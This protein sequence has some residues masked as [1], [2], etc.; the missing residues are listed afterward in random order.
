MSDRLNEK[1]T[2]EFSI[3]P[4]GA[5]LAVY[6]DLSYPTYNRDRDLIPTLLRSQ[7][8]SILYVPIS[9]AKARL[10]RISMCLPD[11][12]EM[13]PKGLTTEYSPSYS[14]RFEP[15]FAFR[16]TAASGGNIPI[17]IADTW[18]PISLDEPKS[19]SGGHLFKFFEVS[20]LRPTADSEE[21]IMTYQERAYERFYR[22]C[23]FN[24]TRD[25]NSDEVRIDR[26]NKV[27]KSKWTLQVS[28]HI[29]FNPETD[30]SFPV[31]FRAE[32]PKLVLAIA[33]DQ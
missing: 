5:C 27:T 4:K 19:I 22:S 2:S 17:L 3:H 29:D 13:H 23:M 25:E 28:G 14:F 21:E 18:P 20:H 33:P 30:T 1:L 11:L 10:N 31:S 8:L 6:K 9:P 16:V 12:G 26:H 24:L 7:I 15:S 32:E